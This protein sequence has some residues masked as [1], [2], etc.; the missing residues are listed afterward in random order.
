VHRRIGA[1]IIYLVLPSL[2]RSISLP[3]P[4]FQPRPELNG[5]LRIGAYLTFQRVRFTVHPMSPSGRWALT[6]PFHLFPD[7]SG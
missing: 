2:I 4:I 3:T 5:Q 1:L 6:S 7:E